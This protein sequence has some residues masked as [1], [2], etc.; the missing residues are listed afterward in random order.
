MKDDI[1]QYKWEIDK[2]IIINGQGTK[3]IKVDFSQIDDVEI[4]VTLW[5][6]GL[7]E[8][9][10]KE[11]IE[12]GVV[13]Q[14]KDPVDIPSIKDVP[15]NEIKSE[16]DSLFIRLQNDPT[17]TAY[18]IT[19]GNV[20]EIKKREQLIEKHIKTRNYNRSRIILMQS[21]NEDKIRTEVYLVPEGATPPT[22]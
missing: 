5:I 17:T 20:K 2:G 13:A 1:L 8:D 14:I 6:I 21:V 4:K 9:C 10:K 19:Y 16:I 12:T 3:K 18:L 11:Y 15:I 7:P 22:P